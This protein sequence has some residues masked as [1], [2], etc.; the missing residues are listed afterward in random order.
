MPDVSTEAVQQELTETPRENDADYYIPK[1]SPKFD[2]TGRASHVTFIVPEYMKKGQLPKPL[3]KF[4]L[5]IAAA[6]EYKFPC[7]VQ[8]WRRRRPNHAPDAPPNSGGAS[9]DP[10]ARIRDA[11]NGWLICWEALQEG[12]LSKELENRAREHRKELEYWAKELA[13]LTPILV[14][15]EAAIQKF[16]ESAP[17][18]IVD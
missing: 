18:R 3:E 16:T 12:N 7:R 13:E 2:K 11:A 1:P 17:E 14:E 15:Y 10:N 4:E 6:I 9:Q 8:P 5:L